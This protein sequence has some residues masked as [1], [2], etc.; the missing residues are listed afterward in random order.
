[1]RRAVKMGFELAGDGAR[2]RLTGTAGLLEARALLEQG[3]REFSGTAE[4]EVDLSAVATA[5]SAGLAV[6]LAWVERARA[7]GQVLKFSALPEQLLAIARVC[8]VES[9]LR[10]AEGVTRST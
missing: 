6:L 7:S 2:Y 5:D 3:R 10:A 4:V 9:M 8:G 1:M